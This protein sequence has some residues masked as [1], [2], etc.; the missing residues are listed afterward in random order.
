MPALTALGR[1]LL[2]GPVVMRRIGRRP[3][4]WAAR[5]AGPRARMRDAGAPTMG[6][7]MVLVAVLVSTLLWA[8][9]ANRYVWTVLFT[10]GA[11]GAIGFIDDWRKL[12]YKSSDGLSARW[13][14]LLQSLAA[15]AAA[16]FLD[17]TAGG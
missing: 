12:K 16:L 11:F 13:K 10:T 3:V 9:L 14:Y 5:E 6:G 2:R 8:D 1:S 15:L 7:T 17:A 4:G